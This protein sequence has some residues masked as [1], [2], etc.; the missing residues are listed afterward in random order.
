MTE[1]L[2]HDGRSLLDLCRG[3]AVLVVFLRH[4]GCPFCHEALADLARQR[5]AIEGA[6]V[7]IAIVHQGRE[8]DWGGLFS[9]Y[10]VQD[11]PR[12]AD[13][14]RR[15]YRAFELRRGN[16]WQMF[17][18]KIWWRAPMAILRGARPGRSVGDAFQMPGAFVVRDGEI[19][20]AFRHRSQ[21]DRP[22]YA[23]MACELPPPKG[24]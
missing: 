17:G 24:A 15:L 22:D 19:I 18:P 20:S 2:S 4:S 12:V 9:K 6:G 16:L 8:A 5:A 10:G 13:P 1:G 14:D 21:A 11:L 23:G 7:G 3:R